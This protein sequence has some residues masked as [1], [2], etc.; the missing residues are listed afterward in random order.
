MLDIE[1]D[2][3][4]ICFTNGKK[5][6]IDKLGIDNQ[7]S[8]RDKFVVQLAY[9]EKLANVI[10]GKGYLYVDEVDMEVESGNLNFKIFKKLLLREEESVENRVMS[11]I[12]YP[13]K[14][15]KI[16]DNSRFS[17][18]IRMNYSLVFNDDNYKMDKDELV[19]NL[20]ICSEEKGRIV[21]ISKELNSMF[22]V[23]LTHVV[24]IPMEVCVDRMVAL[25]SQTA[26]KLSKVI[27]KF[28]GSL[29]YAYIIEGK[30]FCVCSEDGGSVVVVDMAPGSLM[31]RM[32]LNTYTEKSYNDVEMIFS[33]VV[34]ADAFSYFAADKENGAVNVVDVEVDGDELVIR[35]KFNE[36]RVTFEVIT[37]DKSDNFKARFN[38]KLIE[39]MIC[40][41]KSDYIKISMEEEGEALFVRIADIVGV[42][43]DDNYIL[44]NRVYTTFQ[45]H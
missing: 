36:T 7:D 29:V 22:A 13:V 37:G 14:Y 33:N 20:D 25:S 3:M 44:G 12:N 30:Y 16:E 40:K 45:R 6:I 26:S 24:D 10:R 38:A 35:N 15:N 32:R 8:M 41:C 23:N 9:L 31:D 19:N 39:E 17:L 18:F 21:Y 34:I 28:K 2:V 1:D 42:Q 11:L 5:S 4:K 43:D 27:S